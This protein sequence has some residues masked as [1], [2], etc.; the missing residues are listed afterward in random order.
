M[1]CQNYQT[2][3]ESPLYVSFPEEGIATIHLNQPQKKNAIS[4]AMMRDMEQAFDKIDFDESVRAVI[5]R[6][7]GTTFCSCGD[8]SQGIA[9][10]KGP[11][12]SCDSLKSYIRAVR[13]LRRCAKPVICMVDGYAVGGGFALALASD[14][15][16]AS[17]RAQFVPA[18]CQIG[19]ATEMGMAKHLIELVGPHKAKEILFLGGR[20]PAEK[21]H[22]MGLV[23][24]LCDADDL[25]RQTLSA[26]QR[27]AS[28]PT[29]SIQ[30]AK[31]LVNGISDGNFESA[32]GME[33]FASPLCGA[34]KAFS[35]KE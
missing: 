32:V 14:M 22:E 34:I 23:N 20:I 4:V 3:S 17:D 2:N 33:A 12:G 9:S 30:T 6:G 1:N 29:H 15:I 10:C 7:E 28:M 35:S 25:E 21:L 31:V 24:M 19:I 18:F 13:A 8:L 16:F 27:I 26:A 5:L 11:A